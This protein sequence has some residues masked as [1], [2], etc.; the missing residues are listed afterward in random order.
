MS[1]IEFEEVIHD[2][3]QFLESLSRYYGQDKAMEI[4]DS[5]GPIIGD[6]IRG[7]ILFKMLTGDSG[8][9]SF[10]AGDAE[11]GN[12]IS[13]IK[14]I[15]SHTG[16]GLREAKDAWDN[17]RVGRTTLK[18]NNR[19]DARSLRRELRILGCEVS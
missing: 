15:R 9:V 3:I 8:M 14:T 10:R 4:W 17:S 1:N 2:G 7:Q 6:E 11:N 18:M 13:V 12:A 5:L 19:E 16:V